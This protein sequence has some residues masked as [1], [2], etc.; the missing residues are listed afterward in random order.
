MRKL[1]YRASIATYVFN[2][3]YKDLDSSW[4]AYLHTY[5]FSKWLLCLR[6]RNPS[7]SGKNVYCE[8]YEWVCPRRLIKHSSYIRYIFILTALKWQEQFPQLCTLDLSW[9]GLLPVYCRYR[10]VC[11]LL[12][13]LYIR[14]LLKAYSQCV[15][16]QNCSCCKNNYSEN[17][18]PF[19]T[20][21]GTKLN[22]IYMISVPESNISGTYITLISY[23]VI[24][25]TSQRYITILRGI[26]L[27]KPWDNYKGT[28]GNTK[29]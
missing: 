1:A 3:I 24:L 14:S 7:K 20:P 12:T 2:R 28:Y 13:S 21:G 17:R 16:L 18:R 22:V 23:N 15:L 26:F 9:N 10:A 27:S 6:C 5:H 4:R 8:P 11:I 19:G 29:M 25:Y